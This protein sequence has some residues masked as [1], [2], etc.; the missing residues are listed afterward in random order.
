MPPSRRTSRAATRSPSRSG[1]R[2]SGARARG[3]VPGLEVLAARRFR[4]LAGRRVG[5]V[6]NPTSV[7]RGLVHA[8]DL[9]HAAPGVRL[10]ALF[11]P[12]HGVRGDAQYMAAVGGERDPRTGLPA[13][14]LY[15]ET[16][17]SLRPTRA[18]LAGLDAL[19]FDIQD[20]GARYYTYQATMMLC[21]EAAA[22]AGLG[23]VVLDRPNPIGGD[24]VEGPG[25][26]PGFESFC[27]LHDL[28]VRHGLTVGELALLFREERRLDLD[29]EVVP[30]RGW[31][32]GALFRDT[33]LPWVLPSP[34][35]PTPETA[36]VYPGMCLLEGT[37]LS[38]GR[39]TARPFETFGAPWLD[40]LELVDALGKLALPGVSFLPTRFRPMFEKHANET[41]GG[42]ILHV[43]D[44]ATFQPYETGL[45]VIA[46]ARFLDRDSFH[47]RSEPYEFDTRP[48][49]DVLTGSAR[50]R[51]LVDAGGDLPGEIGRN[52]EEARMFLARRD[53]FLLYP[54]HRPAL[55]AFVGGHDSGKTTLIEKLVPR[56]TALG[57]AVG[58]VKHSS[59]HVDD[60]VVGKDSHRLGA[61]GCDAWALV[62]P[63]RAALWRK[64]GD[65]PLEE[66]VR[67]AFSGFDLV[68]IEG[69]KALPIPKIEVVRSGA[70]RPPVAGALARVSDAPADDSVPTY[71]FDDAEGIVG[72]V[73]RLA[74]LDRIARAGADG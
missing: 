12:E 45:A 34:N 50:F 17:A 16:A 41:C 73:L 71:S 31:R 59:R 67:R 23:F 53:P 56:L 19:V 70:S 15:G 18:Q 51:E 37:N 33:G 36:L 20:V 22:E 54:D 32:R 74:G 58:A 68:L 69:F 52:R 26:R 55:V 63:G 39:G 48:A 47:W 42:A 35:V 4:A 3:V 24:L 29:L 60:D 72:T 28:A 57:L 9:L 21:M 30:C 62:T 38:E 25:L 8:A 2:R 14:S 27:G 10:V 64:V 40:P 7:T 49:I 5:L 43:T 6:C 66:I 65:E 13:H 11:G 1:A 46:T 44:P 61:A